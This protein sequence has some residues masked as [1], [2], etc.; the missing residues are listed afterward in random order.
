MK[1]KGSGEKDKIDRRR[2]SEKKND[3]KKGNERNLEMRW[4][5]SVRKRDKIGR[6]KK[7]KKKRLR[8]KGKKEKEKWRKRKLQRKKKS[9]GDIEKKLREENLR[10]KKI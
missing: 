3:L 9:N 4:K 10:G 6:R 5:S 2:K 8:K 1:W 7:G